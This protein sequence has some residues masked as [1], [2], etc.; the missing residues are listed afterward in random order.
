MTY[1]EFKHKYLGKKVDFDGRYGAQ[2]VDLFRIYAKEVYGISPTE[3]VVGAKDLWHNYDK[4]PKLKAAFTKVPV[5]EITQGD[6]IIF[7]ATKNNQYGHV[8]ICDDITDAQ[9]VVLEQDGFAQT[10]TQI[11]KWS[12]KN[13]LGGL[14]VK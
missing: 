7:D 11:K 8:A 9:V 13:I 14:R 2:C 4:S 3:P 5:A 12:K 10:G 1:S 6:V